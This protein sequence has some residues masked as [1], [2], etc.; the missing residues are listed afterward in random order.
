MITIKEACVRITQA[1]LVVEKEMVLTKAI[2]M[3]KR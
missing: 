2:V 3:Q 1:G